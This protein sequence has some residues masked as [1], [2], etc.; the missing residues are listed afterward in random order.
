MGWNISTNFRKILCGVDQRQTGDVHIVDEAGAVR[1]RADHRISRQREWM[2]EGDANVQV[3]KG[4]EFA[5]QVGEITDGVGWRDG[6]R[7]Y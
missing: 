3:A 7:Y 6:R 2:G 4:V 1:H 5:F